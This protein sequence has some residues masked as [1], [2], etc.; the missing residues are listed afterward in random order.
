MSIKGRKFALYI[1]MLPKSVIFTK[2][3][4][5]PTFFHYYFIHIDPG[6][7]FS[8]VLANKFNPSKVRRQNFR[9]RPLSGKSYSK[10]YLPLLILG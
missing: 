5:P 3:F 6:L 9:I 10:D 1:R 2:T 7:I 8:S 4:L